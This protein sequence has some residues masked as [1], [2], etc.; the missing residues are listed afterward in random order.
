M[1]P[2]NKVSQQQ[3]YTEFIAFRREREQALE[4]VEQRLGAKI[5]GFA[6]DIRAQNQTQAVQI[7][8]LDQCAKD[9]GARLEDLDGT[10]G[11]IAT[12]DGRVDELRAGENRWKAVTGLLAVISGAIS[13]LLAGRQ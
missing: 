9:Y 3:F 2:N 4:G 8:T 12:L 10:D 13:G 5:D 7:A 11:T 1:P 6:A